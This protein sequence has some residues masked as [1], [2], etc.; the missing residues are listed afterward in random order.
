MIISICDTSELRAAAGVAM[1]AVDGL[2]VGATWVRLAPGG[3]TQG[4]QHDES[5]IFVVV[6]GRGEIVVDG[7]R[8]PAAAGTIALFEPFEH[9]VVEN[10]SETGSSC[11]R[12]TGAT[13]SWPRRRPRVPPAAGSTSAR[14]SSSRPR[15]PPTATCISA[16]S[17]GPIWARMPSCASSA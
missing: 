10:G 4:H 9:H 1:D 11:W 17:P 7:K 14:C 12:C 15:R 13:R 8:H 3:R 2:P 6:S 16:T 5:E